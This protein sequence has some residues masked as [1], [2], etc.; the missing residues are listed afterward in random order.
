MLSDLEAMRELINKE[1]LT[2]VVILF[3]DSKKFTQP[4]L[5]LDIEVGNRMN[6]HYV[7]GTYTDSV[8]GHKGRAWII[9]P[10]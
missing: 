4:K 1:S 9:L 2:D 8:T 5:D 3:N 6:K 7:K 10:L